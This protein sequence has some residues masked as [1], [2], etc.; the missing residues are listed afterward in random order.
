MKVT[1]LSND[2]LDSCFLLSLGAGDSIKCFQVEGDSGFCV[3]I[4]V[5]LRLRNA[6]ETLAGT[7]TKHFLNGSLPC[8]HSG[9]FSQQR[10][11]AQFVQL[12]NK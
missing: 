7:E 11:K 10:D 3:R 5:S 1:W 12:L 8:E 9:V 2:H 6:E 4:R